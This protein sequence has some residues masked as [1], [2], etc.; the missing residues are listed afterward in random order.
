MFAVPKYSQAL[1]EVAAGY[2][3]KTTFKTTLIKVKGN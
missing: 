3:I 1:T 2:N